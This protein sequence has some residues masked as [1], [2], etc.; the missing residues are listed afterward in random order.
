[1]S[2]PRKVSNPPTKS[3]IISIPELTT[4]ASFYI[5]EY[6]IGTY[7]KKNGQQSKLSF[8]AECFR[9]KVN[10]FA[11]LDIRYLEIRK[12]QSCL[13]NHKFTQSVPVL[14]SVIYSVWGWSSTGN[15][16]RAVKG[17]VVLTPNS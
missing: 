2:A 6:R 12:E 10:K 4:S 8:S 13:Q 17:K 5:S 11:L 7:R 15:E 1:M 16:T 3:G 9:K 14:F